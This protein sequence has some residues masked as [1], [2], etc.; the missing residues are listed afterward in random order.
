M[1]GAG[2]VIGLRMEMTL[3]SDIR[4]YGDLLKTYLGRHRVQAILV[5]VALLASLCLK[6]INPQLAKNFVDALVD[7]R[8]ASELIRWAALFVGLAIGQQITGSAAAILGTN[9]G[10][11]ASNALRLD[12]ARHCLHLDLSFHKART[13]GEMIERIDGDMTSL[14]EFFGQFV[15]S[16][17]GNVLLVIGLVVMMWRVD[18]RIGIVVLLFT[19]AAAYILGRLQ[20]KSANLWD[21]QRET[22]AEMFGYIEERLAAT[23][24][25]RSLGAVPYVMNGLYDVM[26]RATWRWFRAGLVGAGLTHNTT[27]LLGI[28]VRALAIAMGGFLYLRGEATLGTA[29]LLY[30]YSNMLVDPLAE[31]SRRLQDLQKAAAGVR[32]ASRLLA[33]RS[34]IGQST[35]PQALPSTTQPWG[36][37]FEHVGFGYHD[38]PLSSEGA[39]S[40]DGDEPD[41]AVLQDVSF[42]VAPGHVLGLLGRTGSGKTTIG[43]LLLRLY[44]PQTGQISLSI[45]QDELDLLSADLGDLRQRVG[46]VTQTINLFQASIRDNL[47]LFDPSIDDPA[48]LAVLDNLGLTAWLARQER[49]LDTE[50][51]AGGSGLSAGE[52]QLLAFARIFLADPQIVLLDEASSRLDPATEQLLERA[53]DRLLEERTG[54]IIAHR[55]S[56]ILRADDI[57]ILEGG[58]VAEFGPRQALQSDPGSRFS[59]LLRTGIEEALA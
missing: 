36:L 45:D 27:Y 3:T 14:S 59:Q 55:L 51:A 50:I 12:L 13:P 19:T 4:R 18:W 49:G 33:L 17:V 44:D 23:E 57:L 8:P 35:N 58:R 7:G 39:P 28:V 54:I 31:I 9:V 38:T 15:V 42:Q 37:R 1:W 25:I 48:L 40:A 2:F 41:Q 52:G 56:T 16:I 47:T 43:R 26:R 29:Y 22:D 34:R 32:R 30:S 10:W 11:L 20:S 53:V 5:A 46:V 21:Q 24:D 6:L